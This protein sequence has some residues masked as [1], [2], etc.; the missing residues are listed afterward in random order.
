MTM[1]TEAS[2]AVSHKAP[3]ETLPSPRQSTTKGRS[4]ELE[5]TI[6]G[7]NGAEIIENKKSGGVVTVDDA[8]ESPVPIASPKQ[9]S[10][11]G[12]TSTEKLLDQDQ[13]TT[14]KRSAEEVQVAIPTCQSPKKRNVI[15]ENIPDSV[16]THEFSADISQV[17]RIA[18]VKEYNRVMG[19]IL[20]NNS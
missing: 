17:E 6:G 3:T 14:G 19:R 5:E 18:I 9:V 1:A 2:P 20:R 4:N 10:N 13:T 16:F 12:T 15:I 11:A 8:H 7:K